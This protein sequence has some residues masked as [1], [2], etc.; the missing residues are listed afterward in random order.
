MVAANQLFSVAF[1]AYLSYF[2]RQFDSGYYIAYYVALYE[3][4][5]H[6]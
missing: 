5:T 2:P 1:Y 4:N 3:S 6:K